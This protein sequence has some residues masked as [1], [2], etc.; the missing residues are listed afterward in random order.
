M[1][2]EQAVKLGEK[3]LSSIMNKEME[4]EIRS[5]I[6]FLLASLLKMTI[7]NIRFQTTK[8]LSPS[9]ED[10]FL[11]WIERRLKG[12]PVQY[13]TG[14]CE[15]WSMTFNVGDGVLIPR[16]D[17]E[18]LVTE[19]KNDYSRTGNSLNGNYNFLDICCGTGCIGIS[20]LSFMP[21]ANAMF[22]DISHKAIQYASLNAKNLG[23]NNRAKF[24]QSD[25]FSGLKVTAPF[26]LI[27]ANPP[28]IKR[29]DLKGLPIEIC[30]FEP[31]EALDGGD[32]GLKFYHILAGQGRKFL[33]K[34]GRLYT[35]IGYNQAEQVTDIF[36]SNGWND[37][38]IIKDLSKNPRVLSCVL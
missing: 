36:S 38:R 26:D 19:V 27:T 1:N 9:E 31:N 23:V 37:I 28:Y 34:K 3:A 15:F 11:K 13:I 35:E 4:T 6:Y 17:T 33:K 29:N 5:N 14:E 22:S 21:S 16:Q 10:I 25:M 7:P 20:I 2:V 12:E 8:E 24:V 18:T 32:D 30:L